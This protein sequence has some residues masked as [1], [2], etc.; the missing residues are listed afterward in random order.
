MPLAT[1]PSQSLITYDRG[2]QAVI[3]PGAAANV[4]QVGNA[5]PAGTTGY[6]VVAA[7]SRAMQPPNLMMQID[8][9][10]T[11]ALTSATVNLLG[12][13]D[14]IAWGVIGSVVIGAGNLAAGST[15][16]AP[17]GGNAMMRY[18]CASISNL[19][20]ASGAPLVK[21]SFSM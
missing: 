2:S 8:V 17:F 10:G 6:G 16:M 4:A 19:V 18:V 1:G 11:G 3:I 9:Q 12:S 20:V 14:G 13:L 15:Q 21:V 7:L 5:Q